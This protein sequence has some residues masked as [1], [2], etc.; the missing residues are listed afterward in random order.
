MTAKIV[1]IGQQIARAKGF[2]GPDVR[3]VVFPEYFLSGFPLKESWAKRVAL[4]PAG[5]EYQAP[6]KVAAQRCFSRR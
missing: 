3:L 1:R 4:A 2:A 5:A 6:G